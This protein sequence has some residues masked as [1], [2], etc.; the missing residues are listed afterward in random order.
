MET[1]MRR[2]LSYATCLVLRTVDGDRRETTWA[3]FVRDNADCPS[4]LD[5]IDSALN[6]EG[7]YHGGGGASPTFSVWCSAQAPTQEELR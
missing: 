6:Y 7:E 3:E 5:D 2:N 4:L 1:T